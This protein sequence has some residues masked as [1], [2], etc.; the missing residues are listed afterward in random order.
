[1]YFVIQKN[2]VE[3]Y[4]YATRDAFNLNGA[5]AYAE[6]IDASRRPM[7]IKYEEKPRAVEAEKAS[8][9]IK[10]FG[11]VRGFIIYQV[12]GMTKPRTRRSFDQLK[13]T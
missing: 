5:R 4:E 2:N 9:G 1:M 6:T 10:W 11:V 8:N 12:F 7:V 3:E 13:A